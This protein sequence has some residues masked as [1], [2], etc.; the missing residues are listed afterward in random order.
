MTSDTKYGIGNNFGWKKN[1]KFYITV[2]L[3]KNLGF[4]LLQTPRL[5]PP[6]T[7]PGGVSERPKV[8]D[9]KSVVAQATGSSNLPPSAIIKQ[10]LSRFRRG[11]CFL[12]SRS[13]VYKQ[14]PV[15]KLP[16]LQIF[17]DSDQLVRRSRGGG[18]RPIGFEVFSVNSAVNRLK[19]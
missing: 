4:E 11:P 15:P 3:L 10:G 2:N 7:A 5:Q 6:V 14:Q 9:S 17:I 12:S 16:T 19:P 13:M 18:G 8:T 1:E